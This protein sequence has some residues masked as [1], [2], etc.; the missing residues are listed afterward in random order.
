MRCQA[1]DNLYIEKLKH[2][3]IILNSQKNAIIEKTTNT[4]N[5]MKKNQLDLID[6]IT[7]L[8]ENAQ[9]IDQGKQELVHK[10]QQLLERTQENLLLKK[11]LKKKNAGFRRE[12]TSIIIGK[13]KE[14][15]EL[16]G[17]LENAEKYHINEM[18]EQKEKFKY[19]NLYKETKLD[20]ETLITENN[21]LACELAQIHAENYVINENYKK[22]EKQLTN[23][24][25]TIQL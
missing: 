24:R 22:I 6:K 11:E 2:E 9:L 4:I 16:M 1:D 19:K 3:I 20:I 17:K 25:S 7:K 15:K 21:R 13:N 10:H 8:N 12:K 14:I 18:K 23:A 5:N